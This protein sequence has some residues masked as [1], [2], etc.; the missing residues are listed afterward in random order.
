MKHLILSISSFLLTLPAFSQWQPQAVTTDA[1]FRA[2]SVAS[3]DIAWLGGTK[4]TFVRTADGGKTWQTGTVPDAQACD[5]R[6]VQAIDAQTA[7]LMSA[8]PAEQGQARIYKTTDAG[9]HWTLL[10]Q[11]QQK[12]VFFDGIDFWDEQHGLVFSDPID[13]KWFML[14][15]DDGGKTWQPVSPASLPLMEP[16][17]AAFAASGTSLV[18][19]GKRNVWIASGGGTFGRVFRSADRGRTWAVSN[20]PLPAAEATGLFGMRFFTNKIGV[21]VGGNYKQEQLP[22]PNA[23][24]TRDGGQTWQLLTPTDP[25]GLKEAVALLPGDRL[26][27]VGPSGTSLSADQGQTWQRLDTDGFHS[28]ACAKGTCYAVGAKGKVAVQRFK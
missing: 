14:T 11:T 7:Y 17:E 20:T 16:N 26:L 28:V 21:V 25:P 15:T 9:Q 27:T 12:G 2:V 18:V 3:P 19:Q 22:G 8:G 5:F 6:D 10:Y 1:S 4:G 13:G 23:A 24:I